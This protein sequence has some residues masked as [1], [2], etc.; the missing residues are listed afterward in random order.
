MKKKILLMILS[1]FILRTNFIFADEPQIT[2]DA[3]PLRYAFVDGD[4]RKFSEQHWMR[5]DYAGGIEEFSFEPKNLPEDI[6]VSMDGHA[7]VEDNDY[8]AHVLLDK[9]D[10]GFVKFD[11]Q[12]F[13]KFYDDT[14]GVYY[15]FSTLSV[16]SLGRDLELQIGHIRVEAGL[17]LEDMPH[18]TVAYERHFKD[19]SKSRLTWA[20]VKEGTVTRNIAPSFQDVRE[21]V[22]SVEIKI[23]HTVKGFEIKNE[24]V[25]EWTDSDLSREEKSLATTGVAADNK[26][27]VQH[28][29][30]E[31]KLFSTTNAVQKWFNDDRVFTGGAYHFLH[32]SNS[33]IENIFEMNQNRVITNFT[34]PKQIRNA[35]ADNEYDAHTWVANLMFVPWKPFSVTTNV[36]TEIMNRSG[37]S[38]YPSDTTLG[39]PDGI[40][41]TTELSRTQDK[42][43]RIGE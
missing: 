12:E 6:T 26:I 39:I 42:V 40:I 29:E 18:V 1:V 24:E 20:P 14:G 11:Y 22:D 21:T 34:N 16:N 37:N 15:P 10:F 8:E 23:E 38:S 41:N 19:G 43:G 13:S 25:W 27:R 33:E 5:K 7:I 30:P 31:S 4:S 3:M 17:R 9:K 2:V 36:R 32:M 35:R 28:Q